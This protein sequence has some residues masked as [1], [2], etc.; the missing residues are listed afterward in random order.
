V[1]LEGLDQLKNPMISSGIKAVTS[2]LDVSQ[3]C[4]PPRPATRISLHFY[5]YALLAVQTSAVTL[6]TI[7]K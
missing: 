3:P 2:R 6:K 1:R 7:L 4:G 5:F